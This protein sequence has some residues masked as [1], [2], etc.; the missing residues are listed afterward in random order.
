LT[1]IWV[2]YGAVEVSF[3]IRQE[4]LSQVL[5][6][7]PPKLST[8]EVEIQSDMIGEDT[9]L[10]LS[11]SPGIQKFLDTLLARNK[12]I[13]RLLHLKAQGAL[14]RRK[15]QEFGVA[16]ELLDT[17]KLGDAEQVD[18]ITSRLPSQL[19]NQA[20]VVLLS[21]AHYDPIFGLGSAASDLVWAIP[22]LRSQI[23]KRFSDELPSNLTSS[24]A[25]AFALSLVQ[26]L[27]GVKSL[28]LVEK[29]G[30]G[31]LSAVYGESGA[32]H[33]KSLDYW[34]KNLA[35]SL[36]IKSERIIFGCGGFENDKTLTDALA[37]ALFPI[38]SQA[39]LPDSDSKVCM[40]AECSQGLGSEAFLRFVTGRLDPR[41]KLENLEYIDGLD[42]LLAFQKLQREFQLTILTTLP[43]FY[44]GKFDFK[45]IGGAK[46]A[47]SS[48]LHIGSRAK[49]TVVPDGSTTYFST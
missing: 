47:P 30:I 22:E 9:L 13:R 35:V 32:A 41:T 17:E 2:P 10:L 21:S 24:S 48:L 18:G 42:V 46:Q 37:R 28:E 16:A 29:A 4:N 31:L 3:D 49:I 38:L 6:P 1:E 40:L 43:R 8:E 20:K 26:S 14:A 33:S 7:Q 15:A 11:G 27:E 45:T 19:R 34:S 23:F 44:A 5:A 12:G 39:A 25:G 36:P